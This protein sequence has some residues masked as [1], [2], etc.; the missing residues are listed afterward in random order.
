MAIETH[1]NMKK[2][3]GKHNK[4]GTIEYVDVAHLGCRYF[5]F[6]NVYLSSHRSI[7]EGELVYSYS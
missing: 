7:L 5:Y 6:K 1:F 3:F 2:K 4:L